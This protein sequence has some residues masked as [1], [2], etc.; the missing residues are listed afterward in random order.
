VADLDPGRLRRA[1]VV[2]PLLRDERLEL[3]LREIT[4]IVLARRTDGE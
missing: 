2:N 3:T 4:R 1:R